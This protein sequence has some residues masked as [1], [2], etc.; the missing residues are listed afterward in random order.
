M[1]GVGIEVKTDDLDDL[2][3]LEDLDDLDD[4]DDLEDLEEKNI[5][6][7]ILDIIYNSKVVAE[8]KSDI[9]ID[10]R[11]YTSSEPIPIPSKK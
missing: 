7:K 5:Y 11:I 2:D 1:G 8:Y 10:K 9:N 4:L 6:E 3:D